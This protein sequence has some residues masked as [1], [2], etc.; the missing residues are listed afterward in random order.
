MEKTEMLNSLLDQGTSMFMYSKHKH[1]Q[2]GDNTSVE[3]TSVRLSLKD[4]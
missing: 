3:C 4:S 2:V 1:N